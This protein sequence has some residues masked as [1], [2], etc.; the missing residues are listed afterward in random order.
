MHKRLLALALMSLSSTSGASMGPSD[1][2]D[3]AYLGAQKSY[4]A[5]KADAARR[6]RRDAWQTVARKF[7]AMA[8]KYPRS[9]R[10]PDA[11]YTAAQLLE[12]LSRISFVAEDLEAS[13]SDYRKLLDLH[14]RH[15]LAGDG[16]LSL[17]K[18]QLER[19][20]APEAARKTL[21]RAL[22]T[23]PKGDR[24]RDLR[25][26]LASV[27]QDLP[28][29]PVSVALN[30]KRRAVADATP[31]LHANAVKNDSSEDAD[32][33]AA[34]PARA[35]STSPSPLEG[36]L[37]DLAQ[38]AR[39]K[40]VKDRLRQISKQSRSELT[41]AE[42]LGLKVRRVV[43]DAG[44]GGHDSGAV[45]PGGTREK[46]VS[47]AIARRVAQV[48]EAQGLEVT[49]TRGDDTF[50]R[51]EDRAKIANEAH[52]DLFISIHCNSAA[53]SKLHGVETYTLNTASD[54]YSIRLAA[55]ENSTTAKR[56]S[57]LQYILAD[58]A[59]KANTDESSRLASRVQHALVS[60][61]GS[62]Y[63]DV[64]DLGNKEA[65]FY[66]LLGA[67]M[68][69]ILVETSFVSNPEE[70]KRLTTRMYQ[71]DVARSISTGV[72]DFLGNRER[73]AKND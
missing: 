60:R 37:P 30:S 72:A 11:L 49:L 45:G 12:N 71:D 44:H 34:P 18:L 8:S 28:T 48:L 4:Y 20:N 26:L 24:T 50:V 61:L 64:R 57:D 41:L 22:A 59:T 36:P 38:I 53:S 23:L 43:I 31:V 21:Q 54:R 19:Q 40:S 58:L 3:V 68:P 10:A 46:D 47:L 51:L 69:A 67:K 63:K 7:E 14:P 39:P 65:L 13:A 2:A 66:V 17:A 16:A 70:E 32:V 15:R 42:Q 73:V 62:K 5:L 56:M 35:A 1:S 25:A 29:K 55:R 33:A 52:G 9:A 6:K 27:P